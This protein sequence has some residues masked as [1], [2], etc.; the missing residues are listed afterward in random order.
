MK[1]FVWFGVLV[2]I[3][4]I[5]STQA[6]PPSFSRTEDVIYGRRDGTALTL[7]VFTP[8]QKANGAAVVFLVSGGWFSSHDAIDRNGYPGFVGRGYTVFA[9]VHRSQ[10]RFTIQDAVADLH[11]AVRFIRHNAPRFK[12]DPQRLGVSGGSAGGHL[13]LMIGTAGTPG[14]PKAADPVERASSRVQAVACFFPPTDFLNWGS[15]EVEVTK[16]VP[17][18]GLKAP[19]AFYEIDKKTSIYSTVTNHQK[20][21]T[22][23][24][25]LSPVNH[26]SPDDPPTLIVHGDKD[27]LVP[28]QQ[29]E[30]IGARFK[31]A[32]V[33]FQLVVKKG[34]DHGWAGMDKDV[35]TMADWF[36]KYLCVPP[37]KK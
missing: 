24:K 3:W 37:G 8:A 6:A 25:E 13:S 15:K 33:P 21:Q 11:R 9:V 5:N 2:V 23:A 7:D 27:R 30:I 14:N 18:A 34:A 31:E 26:V 36:D 28:L 4:G 10:P 32:G 12:I 22:I 17:L 1:R 20:W 29:A 35:A 19:F 16:F